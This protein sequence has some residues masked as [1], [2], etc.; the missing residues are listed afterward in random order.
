M[1]FYAFEDICLIIFMYDHAVKAEIV[2]VDSFQCL[3]F[4]SDRVEILLH[5]IF[6]IRLLTI[7]PWIF[8][9]S[10]YW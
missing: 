5:D 7:E 1:Y 9:I 6:L 8:K 10:V 4:E 2:L 3:G